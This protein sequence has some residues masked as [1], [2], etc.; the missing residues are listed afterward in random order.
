MIN[1]KKEFKRDPFF[2]VSR[3]QERILFPFYL[4]CLLLCTCLGYFDYLLIKEPFFEHREKYLILIGLSG[5]LSLGL[6]SLVWWATVISNKIVGPHERIIEELDGIL[7]GNKKHPLYTRKG[8]EMY[9]ELIKRINLLIAG[10][11]KHK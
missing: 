3:F 1:M 5:L 8:D 11:N 7:T 9:E 4:M 6:I 10:F 2:N